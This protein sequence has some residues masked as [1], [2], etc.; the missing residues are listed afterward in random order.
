MDVFLA[1][2]WAVG[3]LDGRSTILCYIVIDGIVGYNRL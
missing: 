3:I 1:V 2:F